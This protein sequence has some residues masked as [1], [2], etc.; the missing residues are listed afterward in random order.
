MAE[1]RTKQG[2]PQDAEGEKTREYT[3]VPEEVTGLKD[4]SR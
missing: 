4:K 2:V 3:L 1:G